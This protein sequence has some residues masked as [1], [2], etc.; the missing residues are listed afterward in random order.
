MR[1]VIPDDFPPF[2]QGHSDL[3]A[4]A[5]YGEVVL[6]D[7][8]AADGA[9]LIE[10]LRGADAAINVRAYSRFTAEL[11]E[12]LPELKTIAIVGVGTDNVELEAATRR[13]V[14]V[15]NTPGANTSLFSGPRGSALGGT[16]RN[17]TSRM[18]FQPPMLRR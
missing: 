14:V 5:P 12:A 7:T 6:Y 10:R 2:Y 18:T 8:R 11:L 16:S 9:E 17:S 1:I 4:L 13:G 15:T 3:E